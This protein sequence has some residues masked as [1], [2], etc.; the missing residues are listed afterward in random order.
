MSMTPLRRLAGVVFCAA[1]VISATAPS[2][3]RDRKE[4]REAH[5]LAQLRHDGEAALTRQD[6]A[7]AARAYQELYRRTL[8]PE[9]LYRLGI[10][11]QAQGRLLAAQDLL[12]R[13]LS[14]ARFDPSASAA[15]A[16]EA[17]RILAL[18]RPASGKVNVIGERG[19]LVF[20]D[21][22]L[23]GALPLSRPLLCEPGK[24][25]FTIEDGPRRLE[26][27]IDLSIGRFVEISYDRSSAA[28]LSAEMAAVLVREQYDGLPAAAADRLAQAVEDGLQGERLSPFPLSVALERAGL[29]RTSSCV[30]TDAC[31]AKLARQSELDYALN[32]QFIARTPGAPWELR[33]V[34]L[35]VGVGE[36]AARSQKECAACDPEKGVALLRSELLTLLAT[37]RSRPRGELSLTSVPA[38]A[39]VRLGGR[40]L[41]ATPL[42]RAAWAGRYE[43]E[44][45]LP[46][47]ELQRLPF[48]VSAGEKTALAVT[49]LAEHPEPAPAPLTP[50]P[51][52]FRLVRQP[53]P[54]WRLALGG[55][56]V[57]GGALLAGFG[58]SGLAVADS[59]LV[60]AQPP[61]ELCRER[62]GTTPIGAGLLGSGAA[63]LVTGSV[64]L[65][66]PGPRR[67]V[68]V[69]AAAGR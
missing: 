18:P 8:Q 2:W 67:L 48:T 66:I 51:P 4:E 3:G 22:S 15:E 49:L 28:L 14:D 64:L 40:V 69:P 5:E 30:E 23:V 54:R 17:R 19:S 60:P 36:E 61:A 52:V 58:I 53:R 11:A 12:R 29:P 47:Y 24:R 35:D 27:E 37:A 50:P 10:L 1:L 63:L 9:G 21:G 34:L 68:Q 31:Q 46:G 13:F 39:E 56:A 6:F 41:G 20:V 45:A 38:G 42:T 44:L 55:V 59:C 65:A 33:L 62:F 26:D 25:K 7:A 16:A 32:L 57:V 43:A